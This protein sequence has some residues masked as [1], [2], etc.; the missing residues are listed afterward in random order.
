MYPASQRTFF[1]GIIH[2]LTP[3]CIPEAV[4]NP[5]TDEELDALALT[6]SGEY[7]DHKTQDKL[8]V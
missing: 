6:L 5:W 1:T 2:K 7:Y 8:R 4:S 3:V